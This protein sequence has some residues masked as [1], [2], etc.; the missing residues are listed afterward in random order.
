MKFK[1]KRQTIL[2]SLVLGIFLSFSLFLI[3]YFN[4]RNPKLG[5]FQIEQV[6]EK[7]NLLFLKVTPSH[8]AISYEVAGYNSDGEQIY[9]NESE[10][11]EILLDDF[12]VHNGNTVSFQVK[13]FNKNGD[14]VSAQNVYSYIFQDLS[15]ALNTEHYTMEGHPFILYFD[16]DFTTGNYKLDL[17]YE[18]LLVKSFPINENSVYIDQ[19]TLKSLSGKAVLQLTKNNERITDVFN[20]YVNSPIVGDLSI[21]NLTNE[22][23]VSWDDLQIS[24]QGGENATSLY[25]YLYN[26]KKLENVY[27]VENS[28][29]LF[30]LPASFFKENTTYTLELAAVYKDYFE[31][32]KRVQVVLYVG[33]KETVEPVYVNYNYKNIKENT[34]ITLM[35]NTKDAAIY[36]TL[37]GSEPTTNSLLYTQ[38]LT[39]NKDVTLKSVAVRKNMNSSVV[40]TYD[41]HI[42]EKPL[43]VYLSPSNQ[44]E[45][46]GIKGS[47]YTTEKNMMNKLT[48]Y[49]ETYLKSYNVKVYRN[50]PNTDINSWI[51]ESNYVKSDL[52]LA[53]HSNASEHHDV[54]G[55]EMYVD[56]P[57]S[58]SLSIANQI[59]HR[60]YKIYPNKGK[61]TNRGV[62]FSD[63]SLGEANDSFLPCGTLIEIAYHDYYDD[64]QWMADHLKEIAE[65]IGES[66]LLYYQIK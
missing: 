48:D 63:K 15:F 9:Q 7:E 43:V 10:S 2:I 32:A 36:Y 29:N 37:D 3:G 44:Y 20:L 8:N 35:S 1:F 17:Y 16:G 41:F 58:Q 42:G 11:N 24:Y 55:I 64:A 54:H 60:L 49:L 25:A 27:E 33:K 13:A 31:I 34:K 12:F 53:L 38:P 23:Y 30:S 4:Y 6:Y 59:Y 28:S 21:Q 5:A 52:H 39:I 47:S 40:N 56:N 14:F 46:Y 18:G 51:N 65:N 57:S 61:Y 66:I 45:N 22:E 50:N 62:K 19:G 26:G